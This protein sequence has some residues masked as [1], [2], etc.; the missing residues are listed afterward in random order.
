MLL[1]NIKDALTEYK[2]KKA[3]HSNKHSNKLLTE[4]A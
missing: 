1:N 3:K 2:E 4:T